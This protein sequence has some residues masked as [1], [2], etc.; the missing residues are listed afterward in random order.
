MNITFESLDIKNFLSIGEAHL[1]LSSNGF[2]KVSGVNTKLG[3]CAVS[4]GAGKSA[5]FEAIVWCLTGQ[6]I[7]G[8]KEVACAYGDGSVEVTLSFLSGG[9]RYKITR[10]R[11][12]KKP[13]MNILVNNEDKSGKGVRESENI[14]SELLPG[15]TPTLIGSVIVLGQGL[16]CR[17]TSY[18][19]SG[20]KEILETLTDSQYMVD[21]LKRQL[22]AKKEKLAQYQRGLEDDLLTAKTSKQGL[23]STIQTLQSQIENLETYPPEELSRAKDKVEKAEQE[24]EN[25]E[26]L[27][28]EKF[29]QIEKLRKDYSDKQA[30]FSKAK[31]DAIGQL[32]HLDQ[33]CL[34]DLDV[35]SLQ[36]L[37]VEK[38]IDKVKNMSG[39]CPTCKQP[40]PDFHRPDT[41]DLESNLAALE[42]RHNALKAKHRDYTYEIDEADTR[43][44]AKYT[45]VLESITQEGLAAK[46]EYL[47]LQSTGK[48]HAKE[49]AQYKET[50][51]KMCTLAT[52]YEAEKKRLEDRKEN[53]GKF[54]VSLSQKIEN[55]EKTLAEVMQEVSATSQLYS[56]ATRDFRGQLLTNTIGT[57]N[58]HLSKI[59][60]KVFG[61]TGVTVE[62][63]G[64]EVQILYDT[65]QYEALSGGEK[66]KV[67]ISVQ[68][69]IR[70][71]L[72]DFSGFSS[73][74]I[75]FDEVFDNLDREGVDRVLKLLLDYN[76]GVE[77]L[78]FISH[79]TD[80][81]IP[82][83]KEI[84]VYKSPEGVSHII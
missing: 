59:S 67:D 14:L 57:L 13:G 74:I 17:F 7:R 53:A 1:E 50:Y 47:L 16:P 60:T 72:M 36:M 80:I 26:K 42:I 9:D 31:E 2:V 6:T 38:E 83:D 24:Y 35:I 41:K 32:N 29:S 68:L 25:F 82:Y 46:E 76:S 12:D 11:K 54:L 51:T 79:H 19:P 52:A 77:S 58:H 23:E 43:L 71:L 63:S 78:Y 28:S 62:L 66:Q 8:I 75:V 3:D 39:I 70:N 45:P 56:L 10:Y 73:N 64:N 5:C 15:L 4:N 55:C 18:A 69:A 65:R 22:G 84:T 49:V 20:R 44:K 40:L 37:Q 48:V 27:L 61:G 34:H 30:E 21:S 33:M 81:D